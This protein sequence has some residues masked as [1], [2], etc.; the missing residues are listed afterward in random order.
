MKNKLSKINIKPSLLFPFIAVI[1][2][3]AVVPPKYSLIG[4]W[5]I[6][7]ADGTASGEYI[8]FKGDS[9]YNITLPNGGIGERG[10]Y[11][12]RDS[13]FSIKNIKDVCGKDYWVNII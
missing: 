9:T 2:S 3:F 8:F 13:I 4:Q 7:Y 11:F 6:L 10:M 12:L 5:S 1:I